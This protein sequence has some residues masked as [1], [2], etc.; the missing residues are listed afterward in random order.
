[1]RMERDKEK[2]FQRMTMDPEKEKKKGIQKMEDP[3]KEKD[4]KKKSMPSLQRKESNTSTTSSPGLSSRVE[5]SAGNGKPLPAKTLNEMNHSFGVDFGNVN[6][7]D[8]SESAN[9]NDE[10]NAHAFTYGKDIYFNSGKYNPESSG[11]KFLLAHELTH[12]VQQ[13]DSNQ[14]INKQEGTTSITATQCDQNYINQLRCVIDSGG[15]ANT[16]AGGIPTDEE[17]VQYN[18]DCKKETH[19]SGDNITPS[20]DQC[21][22]PNLDCFDNV[23]IC[24]K[25]LDTSPVGKHAFF[26][27]GGPDPGNTTYSLQPFDMSSGSDCWQGVPGIDYASD[28]SADAVC[29]P[30]PISKVCLQNEYVKYP[31]GHYCTLGPNSNTFAGAIAKN[32]GVSSPSASGWTPGIDDTPPPPG[33]FA[34]GKYRTLLTGCETKDCS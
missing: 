23:Y 29:D 6:I 13:E 20:S 12:V 16:R 17:I 10:L 32:C 1:M 18:E 14:M 34:P 4:E 24:S 7:H 15:C 3:M 22:G 5:S 26:R 21:I 19:Y 31:Q 8:N 27:V 25:D 33:T 28:K 30:S 2:P 11:G 9:M